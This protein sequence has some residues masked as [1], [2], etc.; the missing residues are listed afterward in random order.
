M[1]ANATITAPPR[2]VLRM[3]SKLY[4]ASHV[5]LRN[6]RRAL[7]DD[8][9]VLHTNDAIADGGG[10]DGVRGHEDRLAA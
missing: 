6:T 3:L 9:A 2:K 7:P 4:H 10:F 8:A 5:A 1:A